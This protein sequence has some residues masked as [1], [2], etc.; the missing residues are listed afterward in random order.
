MSEYNLNYEIA[1]A[2]S[3]RIG[4]APIP[5]DSVYEIC[6]A[7][8]NELGGEPAEFDS[9][10]EI[11]L[12]ILPL[13][14]GGGGKAIE[15][16]D[17]LPDAAEN[18]EKFFRLSSDDNVYVSALKSRN[19]TKTNRLP[20]EQQIDKAYGFEDV[21][22]IYYYKGAWKFI[23]TDG[24]VEGYGW[25]YKEE[26]KWTCFLT[27]DNA[28]NISSSSKAYSIYYEDAESIDLEN[29]TITIDGIVSEYNWD[30]ADSLAGNGVYPIPATYNAPESIQIG[31]AYISDDDFQIVCTYTGEETTIE[32][33]GW[34]ETYTVYKWYNSGEDFTM[35]TTKKASE[36]Y[37]G[38]NY[39]DGWVQ[40]FIVFTTYGGESGIDSCMLNSIYIPQLNAPDSEQVNNATYT[41]T[42]DGGETVEEYTYLG[43]KNIQC[44]DGVYLS[45]LWLQNGQSIDDLDNISLTKYSANSYYSEKNILRVYGGNLWGIITVEDNEMYA[46]NKTVV[47]LSAIMDENESSWFEPNADSNVLSTVK[48]QRTETTEEWG[49]EKVATEDD[50]DDLSGELASKANQVDFIIPV[51]ATQAY[52]WSVLNAFNTTGFYKGIAHADYMGMSLDFA[53]IQLSV[54]VA[55]PVIIQTVAMY[56][57]MNGVDNIQMGS[58]QSTDGGTTWTTMTDSMLPSLNDNASVTSAVANKT[59]YS[60]SKIDSLISALDQRLTALGG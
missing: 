3:Q 40:D 26:D 16:V 19:E 27:Q 34:G 53:A 39:D 15:E 49:W 59:T 9:V 52:D 50:V 38:G 45:H 11:L 44:A 46:N 29:H 54:V 55:S 18:K 47:E 8:Y 43:E 56:T 23:L 20:D 5:F 51:D 13:A 21:D 1:Q 57:F 4:T 28:V 35:Y 36:M 6:L 7:I 30:Y 10:Y 31:N 37:Y 22:T 60:R 42:F 58:R 25:L 2:I 12:G 33:T 17:E 32:P 41:Q 24:E 48:Y 14:E